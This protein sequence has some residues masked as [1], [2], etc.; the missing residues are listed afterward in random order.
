MKP[1]NYNYAY[2]FYDISE[3]E[4]DTG[5]RR[6]TKVF[7]VCKKYFLHHQKSVFKGEITPS[8][9][10]KFKAEIEKIIDKNIDF[11]SIIRLVRQSDVDEISIGGMAF[12]KN[13]MFL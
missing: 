2:V 1:K 6:V 4:S 10:I 3:L 11:V 13:D 9:F 12:D 7:K 8:N 5:K